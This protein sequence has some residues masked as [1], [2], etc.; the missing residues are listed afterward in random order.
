MGLWN[1]DHKE[2]G[3]KHGLPM[4]IP[5]KIVMVDATLVLQIRLALTIRVMHMVQQVVFIPT[6]GSIIRRQIVLVEHVRK[7]GSYDKYWN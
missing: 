1:L 3:P 7:A 5:E 6:N 2:R 4:L